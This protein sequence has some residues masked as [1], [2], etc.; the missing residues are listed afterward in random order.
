MFVSKLNLH[1]FRNYRE[2]TI[3][4]T[5]GTNIICGNNANGKT[6]ILEAI[7]LF[8]YGKSYRCKTDSEMIKF[9]EEFAS[10]S[11]DFETNQR[12]YKALMKLSLGGK[13][14]ISVNNVPIN[15]L[16]RL[17][18][19]FHAVLF[20]PEDLAL[21]KGSPGGR[22]KFMDASLCR[23]YPKYFMALAE[24]RKISNEKNILLR[25][26]RKKGKTSDDYLSLWNERLSVPCALIMEYRRE[27]IKGI[28]QF[29]SVI[30]KEI[31]DEE[32]KIDYEA[33]FKSYD[34]EEIKEFLD[35]N[36]KREIESGA[37]CWGVQRDDISIDI[38]GLD[39][40]QFASQGQQRTTAL[41]MRIAEAEYI[42]HKTE[43]YPV[44]LLDDI[45]SELDLK[46]RMY[47]WQKIV[48]KQVIITCTDTDSFDNI[49]NARILKCVQGTVSEA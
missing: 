47:L 18:T 15:K 48:D 41:S 39:A 2:Q 37:M 27:Y 5:S 38:N 11:I 10:V 21:V 34:A 20:S 40:R 24:Y 19:Y 9:G 29:A 17:M 44:L 45:F 16:S 43:E 4:F 7:Y 26:L 3:D 36:Q 32:L 30:Q 28:S 25:Q 6:N 1:N 35:Q 13:K 46:R 33:S 14:S 8:A 49:N 23:L 42:Y 12:E 22:R 31:S